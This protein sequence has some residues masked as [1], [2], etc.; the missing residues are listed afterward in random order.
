[1]GEIKFGAQLIVNTDSHSPG[2]LITREKAQ[3]VARGAGLAEEAFAQ[4]LAA[5]GSLVERALGRK[6]G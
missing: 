5:S 4:M 2:D 3:L 1:M 6:P